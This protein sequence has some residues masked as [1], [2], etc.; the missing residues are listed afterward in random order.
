MLTKY[1]QM[2]GK[3]QTFPNTKSHVVQLL[4]QE[5]FTF[6]RKASESL[7]AYLAVLETWVCVLGHQDHSTFSAA[8]S[9]RG[10]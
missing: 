3:L 2:R 10:H 6:L 5:I 1:L 8:E 4:K 7:S 9:S